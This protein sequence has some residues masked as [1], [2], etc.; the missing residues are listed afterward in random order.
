[1][2]GEGAAL[3][4]EAVSDLASVWTCWECPFLLKLVNEGDSLHSCLMTK[5]VC[6]CED[7]V[8]EEGGKCLFREMAGPWAKV[9]VS[10]FTDAVNL[11]TPCQKRYIALFKE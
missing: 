6:H 8:E 1:M 2:I 7:D 5:V 11:S 3:I 9:D 4:L 10:R